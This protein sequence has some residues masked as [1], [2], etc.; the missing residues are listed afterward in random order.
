ME[1]VLSRRQSE[2]SEVERGG[3]ASLLV[4][5]V[6]NPINSQQAWMEEGRQGREATLPAM[7]KQF[8]GRHGL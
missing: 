4:E 6:L 7:K 1:G 5:G 3:S 8:Y 2:R